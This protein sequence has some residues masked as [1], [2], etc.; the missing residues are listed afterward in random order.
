MKAT[1][2]SAAI[3]LAATSIAS[4]GEAKLPR[5]QHDPM[6]KARMDANGD[7]KV[8]AGEFMS[9]STARAQEHFATLDADG[10]GL[11]TAEEFGA[12]ATARSAAFFSRMDRNSDGQISREDRPRKER[13]DRRD[14]HG[15]EGG[16]KQ[17][18]D[19]KRHPHK[20]G[21]PQP[22]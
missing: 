8:D 16:P 9:F 4:A 14:R 12:A 6:P 1:F 19:G 11:V 15:R 22:E 13:N 21:D 7:R 3:L 5:G 10:D 2:A 18:E 17:K 20:N